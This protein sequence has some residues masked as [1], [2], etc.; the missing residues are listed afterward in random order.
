MSRNIAYQRSVPNDSR[1]RHEMTPLPVSVRSDSMAE[2]DEFEP[3]SSS[4][5][6][7]RWFHP[8]ET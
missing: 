7:G 1:F 8:M 4:G 5:L 3:S 6:H 2:R